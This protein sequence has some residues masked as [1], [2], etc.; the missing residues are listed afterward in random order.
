MKGHNL[1]MFL[2]KINHELFKHSYYFYIVKNI[3]RLILYKI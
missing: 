3:F 2:I 1:F